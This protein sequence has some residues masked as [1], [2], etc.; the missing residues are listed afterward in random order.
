MQASSAKRGRGGNDLANN[1]N[2]I[3]KDSNSSHHQD[4]Q[5]KAW[6]LHFLK[7]LNHPEIMGLLASF[8]ISVFNSTVEDASNEIQ[9]G[10]SGSDPGLP[11]LPV[12]LPNSSNDQISEDAVLAII[13]A[14]ATKG[15]QYGNSQGIPWVRILAEINFAQGNYLTAIQHYIQSLI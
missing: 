7:R 13:T 6:I 2:K 5:N 11:V 15:S 4:H 3:G 1:P 8:F 9:L 14:V 10:S 12:S